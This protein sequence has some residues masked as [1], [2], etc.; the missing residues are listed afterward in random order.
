MQITLSRAVCTPIRCG[1]NLSYTTAED[2]K[3]NPIRVECQ[4]ANQNVIAD[5]PP[6]GGEDTTL[7]MLLPSLD[8]G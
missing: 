3:A 7:E 5:I 8:R 2:A 1:V 4:L 6:S